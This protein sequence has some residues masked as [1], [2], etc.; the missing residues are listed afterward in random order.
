MQIDIFSCDLLQHNKVVHLPVEDAGSFQIGQVFQFHA[1]RASG[2][3]KSSRKL[4]DVVQ[5]GAAQR[6]RKA[7]PQRRQVNPQTM[8]A[9]DHGEASQATLRR[10]SLKDYRQ[11]LFPG[12]FHFPQVLRGP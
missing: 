8:V 2:E 4:D 12:K 3:I 7:L 5:R 9:G 1:E 6:N 10:L 11:S